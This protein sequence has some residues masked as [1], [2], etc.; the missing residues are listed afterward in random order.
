MALTP[1][2]FQL[3]DL[4]AHSEYNAGNGSTPQSASDVD[5]WF[6]ADQLASSM[7]ISEKAV[8]GVVSSLMTAGY[9]DVNIV[10]A[11]ERRRGDEDSIG[12]TE[13]GFAAWAEAR[14]S[15]AQLTD[16]INAARKVEDFEEAERL[17]DLRRAAEVDADETSIQ[18][19]DKA[20]ARLARRRA[21]SAR[22][23]AARKGGAA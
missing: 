18:P 13:A 19:V 20:A 17:G 5:V 8:G 9:V 12:F 2:Q 7:G 23:R 10:S 3:M 6:W 21:A 16:K 22:R 14:M 11:A 4:V 15:V 1:L